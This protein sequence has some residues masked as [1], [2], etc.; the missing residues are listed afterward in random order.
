MLTFSNLY[1]M[2]EDIGKNVTRVPW[3]N[4]SNGKWDWTHDNDS[5]TENMKYIIVN[6]KIFLDS[7]NL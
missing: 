5:I 1:E 4:C 3:Q 2:E 7:K 6:R